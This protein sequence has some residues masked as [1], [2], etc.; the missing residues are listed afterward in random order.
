MDSGKHPRNDKLAVALA[1]DSPGNRSKNVFASSTS[2]IV[3][4]SIGKPGVTAIYNSKDF[5]QQPFCRKHSDLFAVEQKILERFAIF[6]MDS[7]DSTLLRVGEVTSPDIESHDIFDSRM[8]EIN[9]A[10]ERTVVNNGTELNAWVLV[11]QKSEL[12][13][14]VND[15]SKKSEWVTLPKAV[16]AL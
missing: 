2:G 9:T 7:T 13:T 4:A 14:S 12:E 6:V 3:G 10:S 5:S 11:L 15:S 8:K 1:F 16:G